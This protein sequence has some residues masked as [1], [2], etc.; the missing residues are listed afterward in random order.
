MCVHMCVCVESAA[1]APENF[2]EEILGEVGLQGAQ[3]FERR[4]WPCGGGVHS[5]QR[6][7]DKGVA[8]AGGSACSE[9]TAVPFTVPCS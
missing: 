8:G 9:C 2:M 5:R 3:T 4:T 7:V 6:N 1:V